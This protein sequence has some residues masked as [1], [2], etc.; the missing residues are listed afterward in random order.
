MRTVRHFLIGLGVCIYV[1]GKMIRELGAA[2]S[3]KDEPQ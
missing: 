3:Y 2:L 1:I